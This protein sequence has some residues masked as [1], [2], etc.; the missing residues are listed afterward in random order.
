MKGEITLETPQSILNLCCYA[1]VAFTEKTQSSQSF[2]LKLCE[3]CVK[4]HCEPCG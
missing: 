4:K 3:L 1:F 2:I